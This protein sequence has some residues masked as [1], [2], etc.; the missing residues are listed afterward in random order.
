MTWIGM[1]FNTFLP[2]AI[3]GDLVK[4]VYAKDLDSSFSKTFLVLTALLDRIMGL[5]G[6]I[7][8]MG[9][10]SLLSLAFAQHDLPTLQRF[11]PFNILLFSGAIVFI[12]CLF[13]PKRLQSKAIP[14]FEK[15]P[16]LGEHL[17]K[18]L[19]QT[20]RIGASKK[21]VVFTLLLSTLIQFGTVLA[22]WLL[23]FPFYETH[24]PFLT[25]FTFIPIGLISIAVPISPAGLGVGHFVFEGLFKLAGVSGGASL[26][27][28]YFMAIIGL[29]FLG[30]IPYLAHKKPLPDMDEEEELLDTGSSL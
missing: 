6:L 27:N 13:A 11:L 1:F 22:F 9:L 8:I 3:S 15:I 7:V 30:I 14:L 10:M 18:T 19:E 29:N 16:V 23:T 26:F 2:G 4:L 25:L 21:L 28:I 17:A 20:W 12:G 5:M 24:V